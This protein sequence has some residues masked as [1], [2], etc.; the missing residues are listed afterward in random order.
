MKD[1]LLIIVP[2]EATRRKV[3]AALR[4]VTHAL[5]R[6]HNAA[7]QTGQQSLD[8]RLLWTWFISNPF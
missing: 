4:K 2:D 8:H 7:P 1:I 3:D 6:Q 5:D